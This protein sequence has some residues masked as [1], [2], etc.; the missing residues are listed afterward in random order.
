MKDDYKLEN[1][2]MIWI[3]RSG[4]IIV[5][6]LDDEQSDLWRGGKPAQKGW[7]RQNGWFLSE[8]PLN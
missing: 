7:S 8:F 3:P 4:T 6:T 1:K 5:L 2:E